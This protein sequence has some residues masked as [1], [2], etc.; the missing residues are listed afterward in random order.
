MSDYDVIA[1]GGGFAGLVAA[2]RAAQLGLSALVLEAQSDERY[3]CNSRITTGVSHIL[4]A[5]MKLPG[6]ELL[7][8]MEA[9]TE[10]RT[11]SDLAHALAFNSRRAVDWLQEEGARFMEMVMGDG[12]RSL[13]LAPPRRFKPGLD[14]EGRGADYLM[15][16]LEEN[17]TGRGGKLMRGTRVEGLIMEDGICRGVDAVRDGEPIS[18]KSGAVIIADGGFGAN[19]DMIRQYISPQADGMLIRSAPSAM[20]DGLRLAQSAGAELTGFGEFYGHP[21]HRDGLTSDKLWPFPMIDQTVTAA[22]VVGPDGK[23]FADEGEGG[24][25]FSNAMAKLEDPQSTTL[26]LDDAIWNGPAKEGPTAANPL[27]TLGGGKMFEAGDLET[28]AQ[29]AG[30]DGAGLARTVTA[31]NE[32]LAQ[33]KLENLEPPRGTD[34]FPTYPITRPPFYAVPLCTGIT[35]TMGGV[36]IDAGCHALKPDGAPIPGLYAAGTTVA[37][38]EGGPSVAYMGGLAKAFILGLLAAEAIHGK[39]QAGT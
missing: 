31:Y 2:N 13:I 37:G 5:N 21:V 1:M 12:I 6:E 33:G 39:T 18:L 26:I 32:V 10:G 36:S 8:I 29:M 4:F 3:L 7:E 30:I 25:I 19:R 15:R 24:I 20:G 17:L 28:L 23:R 22:L 9:A 16:K 11:R 35:G 27:I 38:L 14:W 34:R